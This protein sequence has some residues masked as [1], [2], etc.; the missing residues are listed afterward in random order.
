MGFYLQMRN[1]ATEYNEIQLNGN[2][3][4][5]DVNKRLKE[6]KGGTRL[7]ISDILVTWDD[8]SDTTKAFDVIVDVSN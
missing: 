1:S 2:V 3:I 5:K 8:C 6:M 4:P 7:Y